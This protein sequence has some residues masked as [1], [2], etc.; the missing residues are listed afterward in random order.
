MDELLSAL[1]ALNAR[2]ALNEGGGNHVL[3]KKALLAL[4]AIDRIAFGAYPEISR[5]AQE[6]LRET[7]P[8]D[9]K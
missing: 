8:E 9:L 6:V 3:L 7:M 4:N 5:I 2:E 1:A